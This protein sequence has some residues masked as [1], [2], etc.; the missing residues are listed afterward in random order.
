MKKEM[1]Y[2]D[3]VHRDGRIWNIAVMILLLAFPIATCFIFGVTP[4]WNALLSVWFWCYSV[5]HSATVYLS[6]PEPPERP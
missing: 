6:Y 3:S 4:D 1:S 5:N 2:L